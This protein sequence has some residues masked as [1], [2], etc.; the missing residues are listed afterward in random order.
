ML[1]D[2]VLD[3]RAAVF[4]VEPSERVPIGVRRAPDI[5]APKTGQVRP[6]NHF[7][8]P[9]RV[10]VCTTAPHRLARLRC[11]YFFVF[12]CCCMLSVLWVRRLLAAL[13]SAHRLESV[14]RRWVTEPQGVFGGDYLVVERCLTRGANTFLQLSGSRGWVFDTHPNDGRTLMR[15]MP[16]ACRAISDRPS[17]GPA[18]GRRGV[19]LAGPSSVVS[20]LASL[21]GSAVS[22]NLKLR[23][24]RTG[25]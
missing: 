17:V 22:A 3:P 25:R 19:C 12:T 2:G 4:R 21:I 8:S 1:Y 11:C 18:A 7:G 16:G 6:D 20:G 23:G 24:L 13:R 5:S 14:T 10:N 9:P 15:R